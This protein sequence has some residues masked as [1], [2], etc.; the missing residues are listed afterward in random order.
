[1]NKELI[2]KLCNQPACVSFPPAVKADIVRALEQLK[3]LKFAAPTPDYMAFLSYLD[4]YY[5]DG[6][7]LFGIRTHLRI[8][9]Q[10]TF[11]NLV[12]QNRN[13]CQYTFFIGKLII[14]RLS[15][16]FI[17]YDERNKLYAIIDRV[18]LCPMVEFSDFDDLLSTLLQFCSI[19]A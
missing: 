9:K 12:E 13:F 7:E 5:Y 8:S 18:N 3:E 4:G 17:I 10:Y 16:H 19:T 1:M 2:D 6:L 14:G 11:S 15:E